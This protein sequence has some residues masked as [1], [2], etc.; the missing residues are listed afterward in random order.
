MDILKQYDYIGKDY[1]EGQEKFF[2]VR[3]DKAREFITKCLPDL[4]DKKVL[5]LGCGH[6]KDIQI[7]ESLGAE[8]YGIDTS[9]I[10]I[11][12]A[13]K[14]V[15]HPE[16]LVVGDIEK[17]NFEDKYFDIIIGRHTLHF[18]DSY[19]ETY[20]ELARILKKKGILIILGQHPIK[21]IFMQE[22]KLYG[23]KE[24]IKVNLFK[25]KVP[26]YFKTHTFKEWFSEEFF[27]NFYI[28][29]IEEEQ[30]PKEYHCE[31]RSP[32]FLAF[33]AIRR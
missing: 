2:S 12:E 18:L 10:M 1:I 20:K 3:E 29:L 7:Y 25:N 32:A 4:K 11:G 24:I 9:E 26:V 22:S 28:D 14:R 21:D 15:K 33:K 8:V 5:D 31:G 16:R 13:T 6:G 30:K 19:D 23:D 27:K 17:T